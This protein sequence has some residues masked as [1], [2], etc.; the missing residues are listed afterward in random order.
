MPGRLRRGIAK[1]GSGVSKLKSLF[2][3]GRISAKKEEARQTPKDDESKEKK[4]RGFGGSGRVGKLE[5]ENQ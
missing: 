2:R 1:I 4:G 5:P 3:G